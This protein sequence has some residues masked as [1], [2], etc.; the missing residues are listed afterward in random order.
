MHWLSNASVHLFLKYHNF[1]AKPGILKQQGKVLKYNISALE[2][3]F[4]VHWIHQMILVYLT[5]HFSSYL[6]K[7]IAWLESKFSFPAPYSVLDLGRM[8]YRCETFRYANSYK[9]AISFFKRTSG[10]YFKNL[11]QLWRHETRNFLWS[12]SSFKKLLLYPYNYGRICYRKATFYYCMLM[13]R[14][15]LLYHC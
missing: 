2:N 10:W 7:T 8:L 9:K 4:S 1:V 5:W 13:N 15:H 6:W 14:K 11:K 12:F 3:T